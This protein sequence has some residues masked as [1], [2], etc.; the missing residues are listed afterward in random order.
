[1]GFTRQTHFRQTWCSHPPPR[2]DGRSLSN[3]M[4]RSGGRACGLIYVLRRSIDV[5]P[6]VIC[7]DF[8]TTCTLNACYGFQPSLTMTTNQL[9]QICCRCPGLIGEFDLLFGREALKV[10]FYI[11]DTEEYSYCYLFVNSICLSQQNIAFATVA[12]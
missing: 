12:L 11:H 6:K 3:R 5:R 2:Y 1:M 9:R 7:S 4:L 8:S 10:S